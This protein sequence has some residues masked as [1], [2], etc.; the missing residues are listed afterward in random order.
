M[1]KRH[2][3]TALLALGV[4]FFGV[5][6]QASAAPCTNVY[7]TLNGTTT[8]PGTFVGTV[9]GAGEV[10]QIGD[11]TAPSQGNALV[12]STANPSNY[13]FY[14]GGGSLTILDELGNNGIGNNVDVELDSWNGSAATLVPGASIQIP[15]SS[16]PSAEYTLV[17]N[18][19]LAAG[20]YVLST[21]LATDGGVDP[22]YQ[23]NFTASAAVPEPRSLA[24]L[25]VSLIGLA[26]IVRRRPGGHAAS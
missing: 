4:I 12:N 21:Y 26:M 3:A 24:V 9:G 20:D 6:A 10:C 25:L 18:Q 15:Y 14:F 8:L 13:E 17:N 22:R 5:T 19:S 7:D 1:M 16:G 23:A 11:L 2:G